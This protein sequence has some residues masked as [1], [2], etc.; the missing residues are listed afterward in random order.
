MKTLTYTK[1]VMKTVK[2][3]K[4]EESSKVDIQYQITITYILVK[5]ILVL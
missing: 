5:Y 3:H 4:I 2:M 1:I